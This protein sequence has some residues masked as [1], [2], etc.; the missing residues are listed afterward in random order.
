[1]NELRRIAGAPALHRVSAPDLRKQACAMAASNTLNPGALLTSR[2]AY[3]LAFTAIDLAQ[4]PPSLDKLRAR[5]GKNF[6]VGAC[7]Q[8]SATYQNPV[9]WIAV[10][11]YF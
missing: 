10:V 9:F 11:T 7:Y 6:A 2:V 1:M 4:T 8:S 5:P 3:A